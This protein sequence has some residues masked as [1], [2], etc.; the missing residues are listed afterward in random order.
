MMFAEG[1]MFNCVDYD[2]LP[3]ENFIRNSSSS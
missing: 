2:M 1:A 3:A